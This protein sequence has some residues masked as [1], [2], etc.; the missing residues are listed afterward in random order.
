MLL[1]DN[2]ALSRPD[3]EGLGKLIWTKPRAKFFD[4]EWGM[5]EETGENNRRS[6]ASYSPS[7]KGNKT[8]F[9]ISYTDGYLLL[10]N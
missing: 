1:L 2:L 4:K 5:K 7:I 3:Q 9:R 8:S 6:Q 10:G